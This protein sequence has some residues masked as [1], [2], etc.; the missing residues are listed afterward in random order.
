[1]DE[2]Y[3]EWNP[4]HKKIFR[5]FQTHLHTVIASIYN[6]YVAFYISKTV[7][8]LDEK[9]KYYVEELHRQYYLPSLAKKC[10]VSI[11]K[12]KVYEYFAELTPGQQLYAC[13]YER[14][15]TGA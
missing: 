10:K 3:L 12:K 9:Y 11:T 14:R 2:Y 13:L 15:K 4:Q 8:M 6:H 7:K 1:M 5:K